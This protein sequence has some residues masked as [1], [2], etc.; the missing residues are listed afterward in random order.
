MYKKEV[1]P[2]TAIRADIPNSAALWLWTIHD[3]VNQKLGKICISYDRLEKRHNSVAFLTHDLLVFDVFVMISISIK[4]NMRDKAI[5]F[6]LVVCR[7]L[8]ELQYFKLPD[9]IEAMPMSSETLLDNLYET[10]QKLYALYNVRTIT[11]EEFDNRYM[12]SYA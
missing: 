8:K 3:M 10:H 9:L 2:T 11:R 6:I 4:S 12:N 1:R 7:L 5:D